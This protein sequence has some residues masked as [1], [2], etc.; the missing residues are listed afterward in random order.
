[1]MKDCWREREDNN[2]VKTATREGE[3]RESWLVVVEER[4]VATSI[5]KPPPKL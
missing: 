4:L 3:V 1:M 2:K 5:T